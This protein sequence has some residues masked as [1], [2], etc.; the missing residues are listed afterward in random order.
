MP[1]KAYH[2]YLPLW[3]F[4]YIVFLLTVVPSA[5]LVHDKLF[6]ASVVVDGD[7]SLPLGAREEF[8]ELNLEFDDVFN[9][10]VFNPSISEDSGASEKN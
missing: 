10:D 9:P 5:P 4:C 7:T 2:T 6:S 1:S 8:R 3:P